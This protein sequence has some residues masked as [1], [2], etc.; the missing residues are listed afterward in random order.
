MRMGS[1]R[2]Y[3]E[4][5]ILDLGGKGTIY[6][7]PVE[8]PP[9]AS[10]DR[11]YEYAILSTFR[12]R[13]G[14][15]SL[16]E[17]DFNVFRSASGRRPFNLRRRSRLPAFVGFTDEANPKTIYEIDPWKLGERF[18]GARFSGL[19]IEITSEPVDGIIHLEALKFETIAY[20]KY[21]IVSL[22]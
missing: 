10:L 3:G 8:H 12:I 4:A 19:E 18:A 13:N 7:L 9:Q 11:V 15:G 16:S 1:T 22:S 21:A 14:F 20:F 2:L 17:S 5:L 6:I